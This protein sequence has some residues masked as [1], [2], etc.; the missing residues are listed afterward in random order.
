[1]LEGSVYIIEDHT[2]VREVDD[3]GR[4]GCLGSGCWKTLKSSMK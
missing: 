3:E 2:A 4:R 1:V